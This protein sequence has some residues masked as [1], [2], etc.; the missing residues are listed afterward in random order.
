MTTYAIYEQKWKTTKP[1]RGRSGD[2]R[3]IGK[4]TRDWE[5][6]V[7][8][9]RDGVTSYGAKLH[10]T[11]CV[12]YLPNGNVIVRHGGL[13]T[14]STAEF[15]GDFSQFGCWKQNNN[16]WIEN[17]SSTSGIKYPV[18]KDGIEFRQEGGKLVPVKEVTIKKKVVDRA[19]AREARVPFQPFL[20]YAKAF[21]VM[22]DGWIMHETR[23]QVIGWDDDPDTRDSKKFTFQRGK[24]HEW[25]AYELLLKE[26]TEDTYLY[27]VCCL[28]EII[29]GFSVWGN[30]QNMRVAEAAPVQHNSYRYQMAHYDYN[31]PFQRV[32]DAVYKWV[33]TFGEVDKVV[34]VAPSSK[35]ATRVV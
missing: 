21:L 22:S 11:V 34:E 3:P 9:E 28:P 1:I 26:P 13:R 30:N 20:D 5:T 27:V 24:M 35:A 32:K 15:I 4:R 17:R 31:V 2:V 12:E 10:D 6:I 16:L 23:K 7:R 25:A 33:K 14:P 19:K 8:I 18:D 29:G